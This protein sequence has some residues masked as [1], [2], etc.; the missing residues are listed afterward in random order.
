M[1]EKNLYLCNSV[2]QTLVCMWIQRR[3]NP[4]IPADLILS[5]HTN[6]GDP[7]RQ[8]LEESGLFERVY[9]VKS[10]D[11]AR[12]RVKLTR[13]ERISMS[14][15]PRAFLKRFLDLPRGYTGLY[16]ANPDYFSQL[17]TDALLHGD[18]Q[19]K[20]W[21]YEDG[22][23]SYSELF[24]ADLEGTRIRH[25]SWFKQLVHRVV[26]RK[27]E[28]VD[29]ISGLLLFNPGNMAWKPEFPLVEIPKIDTEDGRFREICNKVFLYDPQDAYD[30]K[31]LFMEESFYAEGTPIN[32]VELL[33][34]LARRVGKEN[35]MVKI[36][37]RNP[38][39]RF[40]AEGYKTNTNT[41]IPWEV[42]VMNLGD[43]S[44]KVL[45]TIA[46]SSVLNPILIFGKEVRVYSLYNLVD[47]R[48]CQSKLLS[49]AFWKQVYKTFLQYPEMVC[50][51]DTLDEI[52]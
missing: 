8:R 24:Q 23:L 42:I 47:K 33:N 27:R 40:A 51:C 6:G 16:L 36:H 41:A 21:L 39:N 31:Y 52:N 13:K 45:V 15:R 32:D 43:I 5:D 34:T 50:I 19:A 38:V 37:P 3:I 11:F 2:Y 4:G 1:G 20:I 10:L 17:L 18:P 29:N 44:D 26:Y 9:L 49:G 30:R 28:L 25:D 48:A 7:L 22:M 14:L 12:Y 35:I 46:S